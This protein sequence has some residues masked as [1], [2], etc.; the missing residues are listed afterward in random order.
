MAGD[1]VSGDGVSGDGMSGAETV[2]ALAAPYLRDDDRTAEAAYRLSRARDWDAF[3]AA[4]EDFHSPQTNLMYADVDGNIGFIAPGRVPIRRGGR[5]AVPSPGWTGGADWIGFVP[6]ADLPRALNPPSGRLVNANNRIVPDGYPW[7]LGSEWEEGYRAERIESLLAAGSPHDRASMAAIQMDHVSLMAADLLAP[8]LRGLPDRERHRTVTAML[9]AWSG[10]MARG[11]PEPLIFSAW[12]RA[13]NLAVYADELGEFTRSFLHYRP[14]FLRFV[15]EARPIWCD[16][17]TTE[18]VEDCAS[19]LETALDA[20]LEEL[21]ARFGPDPARWRW[22][23]VHRAAFDHRLLGSLPL[24]GAATNLG[25]ETDGGFYT[26][27][28]GANRLGEPDHPYAHVHGAGVRAV[29]DLAELPQS[30]F[31]IA[32][33]QSGNPLSR[34]YGDQIER[35]RDGGS[36]TLGQSR[37]D[38]ARQASGRLTLVAK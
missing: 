3:V 9:R 1:G 20:A 12:V 4:S 28:R 25:I 13:F 7:Y 32:T 19:R 5:G 18:A 15:L 22:G 37:D 10:E 29:Y 2:L 24:I 17:I 31:M 23:D 26:V 16:D 11:R 14:R 21:T 38:L 33:G 8:M 34:H 27:N 35:W 6:F 36:I 30:R